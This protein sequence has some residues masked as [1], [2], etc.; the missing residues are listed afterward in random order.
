VKAS[1]KM[2]IRQKLVLGFAVVGGFVAVVGC[3]S[4]YQMYWI[5][6]P[7]TNEIPR[8]LKRIMHKSNVDA[9]LGSM[10]YYDEVLTQSAR[11]YAFTRDKKWQQRYQNVEPKLDRLLKQALETASPHEKEFFEA[12]DNANFA[13][14]TME[15]QSISFVNK[16]LAEDGLGLLDS[17][18]Y[19]YQKRQYEQA[20]KDYTAGEGIDYD[21]F[22][23]V[24]SKAIDDALGKS[25]SLA[26]TSAI[27]VAALVVIGLF[28]AI[29]I[30]FYISRTISKPLAKLRGVISEMSAGQL[31]TKFE[32]TSK[33][34]IGQLAQELN[35]MLRKLQES[36]SMTKSSG[37]PQSK[38][39]PA[40]Y[41]KLK[42][43]LNGHT[44]AEKVLH[45]R[46]KELNCLYGLSNLIEKPGN[47]LDDI[48]GKAVYL[49]R[50]GY[51]H[52]DNICVRITFD[53]VQYKTDNFRK[54]EL[55]QY[56]ELKVRDR[57]S[58][59]IEAYYIDEKTHT[60]QQPFLKEERDMLDAVAHRL[61]GAAERI[62]ATEKLQ[63]FRDLID[64]SNDCI[65]VIEPKWGCLIDVNQTACTSLG[66]SRDE[67]LDKTVKDID[68]TISSSDAWTKHANKVRQNQD[69]VYEGLHKQKNGSTFP[70]E[71][72]VRFMDIDK[73]SY[74]VAVA[75]DVTER[76]KSEQQ[77]ARLLRQIE[78]A[79]KE[80]KDF[81][82]IVS[83]DLKAPLRGINNLVEWIVA[84][85]SDKLDDEGKEQM[86][87]LT[88]RVV[89]MR[90]LIEGILN[91]SRVGRENEE[92]VP[93]DLSELV[94][95]IIDLICPQE[96]ITVT[97]ENH[98]PVIHC[99]KTRISQ[100]FQ[101]LLSNAVKYM[102][103]PEGQITIRCAED[104][105]FWQFSVADNGPGIEKQHF[106][107]IFQIFQTLKPRDEYESTGVGLSV[108]R[109]AIEMYGGKI[110]VESKVGQGSTFL[111]TLPKQ[112]QTQ[113][114]HEL[115]TAAAQ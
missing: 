113:H 99:E 83:H 108:V 42:Q 77:Q 90:N 75:R 12:I 101:N 7:L 98:L 15:Y 26:E 58:G 76:K 5:A 102:D 48:F 114:T 87:L 66:Y 24:D 28:L 47:G 45:K 91:Y 64:R 65:F 8:S 49:I 89:R 54:S 35:D 78:S 82:H 95:E 18:E 79:N 115:Q 29:L 57:K 100:V 32:H 39:S 21:Q 25:K 52:A 69:L 88:S 94:P 19:W 92:K 53:G 16:G 72:N 30:A 67:L 97:V 93:V 4:L 80:L 46:L 109:K 33:D 6:R 1:E 103:K 40:L 23:L 14:I 96:N 56:V 22:L 85:Y 71:V 59:A 51:Q 11:N 81:A 63:Q 50:D 27:V 2:K 111:F 104:G 107:K 70:V 13:L 36:Y 17:P 20:L 62:Q 37:G 3:Y 10:R 73:N 84:D 55:S 86:N 43:Q 44:R 34:E 74:M 110:W 61:A 31:G 106:D 68:Q 38:Q 41:T 9:M 60:H 105:Q 112:I